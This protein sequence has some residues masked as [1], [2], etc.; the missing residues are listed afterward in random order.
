LTGKFLAGTDPRKSS[1]PKA[2][3]VRDKSA[4]G[5]GPGSYQPLQSMGRQVLSTKTAGMAVGFPKADRP[6]LIP[7]G[8]TDIGPA[9]YKPPPAACEMQID[10]RK[11]TCATIKFGEGYKSGG[12]DRDKHDLSEPAPGLVNALTC[13]LAS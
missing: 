6:T 10:S 7:P 3:Q 12:K 1:F 9:E 11:P 2:V 5:P 8:A 13:F 4:M